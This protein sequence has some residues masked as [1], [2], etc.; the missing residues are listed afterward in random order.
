[1]VLYPSPRG[2]CWFSMGYWLI[3]EGVRDEGETKNPIFISLIIFQ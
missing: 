1:M 3:G 2:Y